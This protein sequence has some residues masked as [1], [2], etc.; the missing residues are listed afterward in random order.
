[1]AFQNL[2]L[3][4]SFSISSDN[5]GLSAGTSGASGQ[6]YFVRIGDADLTVGK[7]YANDRIIGVSQDSARKG[8]AVSVGMVGITKMRAGGIITRGQA[9]RS[10]ADGSAVRWLGAAAQHI[11]G[12]ALETAAVGDIFTLLLTAGFTVT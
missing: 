12:I 1:M 3:Q 7:A 2:I 10:K 6:Y 9:V 5:N 4:Q 8:E 11:G